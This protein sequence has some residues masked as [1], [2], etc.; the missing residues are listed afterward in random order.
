MEEGGDRAGEEFEGSRGEVSGIDVAG[1]VGNGANKG[2]TSADE[3]YNDG[4][5]GKSEEE[6]DEHVSFSEFLRVSS[7]R[8]LCFPFCILLLERDW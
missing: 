4:D 3:D 8:P 1:D 6:D 2:G 5:E 7:G